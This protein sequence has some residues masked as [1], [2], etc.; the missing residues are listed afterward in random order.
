MFFYAKFE[1]V[2]HMNPMLIDYYEKLFKSE[3]MQK[4]FDSTRKSL[5]ELSE[6]LILQEGANQTDIRIAYENVRK[7]LIGRTTL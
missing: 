6:Q 2:L 3:I 5:K 7:E 1:G 4:Q